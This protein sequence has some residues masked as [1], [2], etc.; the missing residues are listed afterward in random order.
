MD[1]DLVRRIHRL[2]AAIDATE[3]KDL[4]ELKPMVVRTEVVQGVEHDFRSGL[5]DAELSNLAH[6]LIHNMA[7]LGRPPEEV[8]S[9]QRQEEGHRRSIRLLRGP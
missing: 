4:G 2:Y 3:E 6:S 7:N 5:T 1:E 9:A 8:G